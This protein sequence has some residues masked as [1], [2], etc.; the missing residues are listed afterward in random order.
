[1]YAGTKFNWY[2]QSGI[3]Q[4]VE[5]VEIVN[6]PLFMTAI[7]ADKGTEELV[8]L[9]GD[10][11]YK[12]YGRN[13]SFA[14][15]GQPLLQA[16]R[17]ID[18]GAELLVKRVV[19]ADATL[20]NV[21]LVA[22]VTDTNIQSE[23]EAGELLYTDPVTGEETTETQV[24]KVDGEGKP[25]YAK[26]DGTETTDTQG[27]KVDEDG[28][29]LYTKADGT[30]TTEVTSQKV[31]GEGRPLYTKADGTET[32]EVTSQ[33]VDGSNKP[34]YTKADGTETTD[35]QSQ[36]V[37]ESNNPLYI[38]SNDGSETTATDDGSGHNYL[39]VMVDNTP[40]MVANASVMV[41]NTA[42]IVDYAP[43]M[44]ATEPVMTDT[45]CSI[46]WEAQTISNCETYDEVME[47][48]A[49]LFDDEAG[50]YPMIVVTD[51]GRNADCKSI[52]ITPDYDTSR[53]IGFMFYRV[54]E[55]ENT[56]SEENIV[57]TM[58]PNIKYK[59]VSYAINKY[60]MG[61]LSLGTVTGVFEAYIAKLSA[62]T[63]I[64]ES[65][66]KMLD[67]INGTNCKGVSIKGISIDEDSIDLSYSYGVP[68]QSGSNGTQFGDAPFHSEAYG[69]AVSKLFKDEANGGYT[70][71]VFDVDVHKIY[72]ICD[73]NY[74][75]SVKDDIAK[76]VKFREDCFYFRDLG[77]GLN[78]FDLIYE[79]NEKQFRTQFAG[80]Y[81]T[82]GMITDPYSNRRI[83]VT[84]MYDFAPA[85]VNHF[86]VGKA[87]H[88][89][90]GEINGF[91]MDSFIK[92]TVNYLPRV[93]PTVDQKGLLDDARINYATYYEYEGDLIIDSLYTSQAEY[94]QLSYINN[95]LAIQEVMRSV[96][97]ACP[98]NRFKFTTS[99]D[100]SDYAEAVTEVLSHYKSNFDS[101]NFVYLQDPTKEAQK[102]YYAAIEF[103]FNNWAQSEIFDL[104]ALNTTEIVEE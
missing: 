19:A 23:N 55:F 38:N 36:K 74:P 28:N 17:I 59:N 56:T 21:V 53:S 84:S 94:T 41:T 42:I 61:Q 57:I 5:Q 26:A 80:N 62:E 45:G 49:E 104:Y 67:I 102:I 91:T 44:V 34:L 7:S 66:L 20:S 97:S 99:N 89:L 58:N 95:I 43:V 3:Q 15:H 33:K 87:S 76:F 50:V 1:M 9:Y 8:R 78:T 13:L 6:R 64:P 83:E 35:A 90:A 63:G 73:A 101:L 51:I 82:S 68:L 85:L 52:R 103:T 60:S 11:F 25:L 48:A 88:P 22:K 86:A 81:S 2:D 14:K 70:D 37:D 32:T 12:M 4:D 69:P 40:V 18:A 46:K 47:S 92:G 24:Q 39:P 29:P 65:E 79:K 100:F 75:Q 96:R 27:Q 30:E 93:T 16:G 54:A 10:D 31:D 77:L 98:K 71:E 72:A